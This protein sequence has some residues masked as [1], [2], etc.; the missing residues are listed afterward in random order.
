MKSD[1]KLYPM[2]HSL[3]HI[4]AAA[5]QRLWPKAKFG[6]GPVVENGFYYDIDL[7]SQKLSEEDFVAIEKEMHQ[8]IDQNQIFEKVEKPI[9]QALEWARDTEQPYKE[10]LLNDLKRSGSTFAA[11]IDTK[12]L[13]LSTKRASKVKNVSFYSNGDF[14]D[15]CRGPHV[16]S[17]GKVGAFRLLR[18]S[19]AYW[20]GKDTNPQMQRIYGVAF[21]NEK[22]LERHLALLAEAKVRDHRRLGQ[23]LDLFTFSDL[24]GAGLP[25]WTPRGTILKNQLDNF[26]QELRD[27]YEYQEVA[28]PHI[29]K[30]DAYIASGHW[31]KFSDELFKIRTREGHEFAMKP[32]NC[33]HHT[34][35]YAR[36]IHSYRELPVRYRETSMVYRD[37]Q[38]G[39]LS[40]L[41]RVRA[42]TQD[43]AHVF[44]RQNQI[45]DEVDKIWGIINRFYS[46]FEF[47]LRIRFSRYDPN[48]S[49]A[50]LGDSKKWQQAEK[51]LQRIIENH[52]GKDYQEG[53]GEA[54]FYGPKID[55]MSHDSLGREWQVATIQLD[56]NQ[57][58]GFDLAC[59][60]EKGERERVVMI[61]AA[62][63]GGIE[64]FLAVL[65]EHLAGRFPV[66]LAPEQI[67]VITLNQ[68]DKIIKFAGKVVA[69]AKGKGL[70]ATLDDDNES[71][72]KK[73]HNAETMKVPYTVVIGEKELASGAVMPRIRKDIEVSTDREEHTIE[74]FLQTVANE[75]KSR[76]GKTSL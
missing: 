35:I 74:N 6:V 31:Q 19:G 26:V 10:E 53:L 34:Q 46:V 43:D 16:A 50:Y 47:P 41:S 45:I 23:E 39:E 36:R 65:I 59:V 42:I 60:N 57:P 72:S 28:I 24:I 21:E 76:V 63:M 73:I 9:E 68:D 11:E 40:G 51:Q 22:E 17:T 52:V 5:V 18:I 29:T 25:L 55:F 20:R 8:I 32:M 12:E 1:D 33:P 66:W 62:I 58:D 71:V 48:N 49:S 37:E 54:A 70:R 38:S 69:L 15:L 56:F 2:R 61:H 30:K 27:E 13:G 64:R 67:R 75:A 14:L 44:C 3:A 7:G 4:L